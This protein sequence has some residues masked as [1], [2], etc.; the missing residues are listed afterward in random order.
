MNTKKM[1]D[2][3]EVQCFSSAFYFNRGQQGGMDTKTLAVGQDV[4]MFSS[5]I[6]LNQGNVVAVSP[7]GAEVRSLQGELIK[8]DANGRE[9]DAG[10][11]E[12][13]GFGPTPG[14]RFHTALFNGAPEFQPWELDGMPFAERTVLIEQQRREWEAQKKK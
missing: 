3:Q 5:G 8:F 10:R 6:Y 11:R 12:R 7:S 2:G 9:T 4:Y 13:L 1:V 14:D